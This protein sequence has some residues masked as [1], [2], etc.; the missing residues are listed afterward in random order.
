LRRIEIGKKPHSRPLRGEVPGVRGSGACPCRG[1]D[2]ITPVHD[3]PTGA[4]PPA[5]W[6]HLGVMATSTG[7]VLLGSGYGF[8]YA[9]RRCWADVFPHASL[10][11]RI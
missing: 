4:H 11:R 7:T 3:R 1:E 10:Q 2:S 9:R 5:L 8:P 6:Q